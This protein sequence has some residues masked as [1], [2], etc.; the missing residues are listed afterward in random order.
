M[1]QDVHVRLNPG[2]QR[3]KQHSTRRRLHQ[4]IGFKF[5]EETSQMLGE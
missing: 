4:Q 5:K 2:L 3:D 1:M